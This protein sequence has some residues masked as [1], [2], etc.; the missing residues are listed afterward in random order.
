MYN[1]HALLAVLLEHRASVV[2]TTDA[3]EMVLHLCALYGDLDTVVIVARASLKLSSDALDAQ[4]LRVVTT[5][6]FAAMRNS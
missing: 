6:G 1:H 2:H 3:G 4:G 5:P